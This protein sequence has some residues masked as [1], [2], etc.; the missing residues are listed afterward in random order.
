MEPEPQGLRP[1]QSTLK[2]KGSTSPCSSV[3]LGVGLAG[4]WADA[5]GDGAK[6]AAPLPAL[7]P[8]VEEIRSR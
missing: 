5:E 2:T 8:E 6:G 7:E 4:K 3:A 1:T